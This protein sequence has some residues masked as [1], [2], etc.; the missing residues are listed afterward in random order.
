MLGSTVLECEINYRHKY[1]FRGHVIWL[2][3]QRTHPK[4]PTREYRQKIILVSFPFSVL[5]PLSHVK[6]NAVVPTKSYSVFFPTELNNN[7]SAIEWC[8]FKGVLYFVVF[9]DLIY[10]CSMLLFDFLSRTELQGLLLSIP[11]TSWNHVSFFI[12]QSSVTCLFRGR[13]GQQW[14]LVY[15]FVLHC[16]L[17]FSLL[18]I[19]F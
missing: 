12:M 16:A 10:L 19:C 4:F 1:L 8:M 11:Q 13:A 9:I 14:K 18:N 7:V 15:Q 17:P 2:A 6:W 5:F 3:A